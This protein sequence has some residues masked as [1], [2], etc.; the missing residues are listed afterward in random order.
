MLLTIERNRVIKSDIHQDRRCPI[1]PLFGKRR[2][3]RTST[4]IDR[5]RT[6]TDLPQRVAEP[7][8]FEEGGHATAGIPFAGGIERPRV[9]ALRQPESPGGARSTCHT[10]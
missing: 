10:R 6:R 3:N 2:A 9:I 7:E 8:P 4:G 5:I 1:P